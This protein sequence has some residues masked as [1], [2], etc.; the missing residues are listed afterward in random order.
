MIELN[1]SKIENNN[2]NDDYKVRIR[3]KKELEIRKQEFLKICKILD[4]I[5]IKY[6]LQTGVLLGA[7]REN[8]FIHWDWDVEIAVFTSEFEKKIDHFVDEIKTEGFEILF[9]D[10]CSSQLKIDFKGQLT[11]ETTKYSINGWSHNKDKKIYWRKRLKVP[12][13]FWNDLRE[14]ELFGKQHL[15]PYPPEKYLEYHYGDWK[16][17][18]RSSDKSKILTTK[19]SGKSP[20]KE[21][22]KKI[23]RIVR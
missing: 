2:S 10:S 14:I 19:Y 17:P 18:L 16:T 6:F 23:L 1:K 3:T 22:L 8:D 5:N 12:D 9:V 11:S 7:I 4:R 20:V 13:H 15:A 21:F